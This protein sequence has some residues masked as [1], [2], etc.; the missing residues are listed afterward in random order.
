LHIN[1]GW[2]QTRYWSETY[3]YFSTYGVLHG[4]KDNYRK[5]LAGEVVDNFTNSAFDVID[6]FDLENE[7]GLEPIHQ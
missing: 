4:N 5:D 6:I 1:I 7:E 2:S 3:D